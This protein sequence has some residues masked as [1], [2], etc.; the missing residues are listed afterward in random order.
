MSD[1]DLAS[2]WAYENTAS[3][4]GTSDV[5]YFAE[6]AFLAGLEAGRKEYALT[7]EKAMPVLIEELSKDWQ[8][9]YTWQANIAMP[10]KDNLHRN[11]YK[12]PDEHKIA[13]DAAIEFL[14]N[15][16]HPLS[17]PEAPDSGSEK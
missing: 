17:I 10:F 3:C 16:I 4:C 14:S 11:G 13:N 2:T 1:E 9:F 7:L 6:K 12:L 5:Y 15:L 8:Y